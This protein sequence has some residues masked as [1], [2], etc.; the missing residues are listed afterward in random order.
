MNLTLFSLYK[1]ILIRPIGLYL[2]KSNVIFFV[3]GFLV[4][5]LVTYFSSPV[6]NYISNINRTSTKNDQQCIYS[7]E[8]KESK[9]KTDNENEALLLNQP[10][11][12]TNTTSVISEKKYNRILCWV[13]TSPKTHSRAA[14][15]KET[16]GKRCDRLLF[17]SSALGR[18]WVYKFIL[19]LNKYVA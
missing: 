14:L 10:P 16:W 17:M 3:I 15:I 11:I 4:G 5:V 13:V 18:F 9:R 1:R 19:I 2:N 8:F 7:N 12:N 6:S